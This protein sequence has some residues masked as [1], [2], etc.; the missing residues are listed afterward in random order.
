MESSAAMS[1]ATGRADDSPG[2]GGGRRLR[3]RRPHLRGRTNVGQVE[4]TLSLVAGGALAVLGLRRRGLAGTALA[5]AG[6]ALVHRGASGHCVVYDSLGV[7]TADGGR[8]HLE[9]QHGPAAVLD[10]SHAARIEHTVTVARPR[11]EL[12]RYWRRLEN[13]PR[14]MRHLESVTVLDDRR[15]R[16]TAKAPAGTTVE[17]VAVIHNEIEDE[18]LAWKS[19]PG[20]SIANAGSVHFTDAPDG[21]TTLRVL[22]EY[23]PPAGQLGRAVARLL[24]EEP[25]A[26]VRDDL[27]RFRAAMERGEGL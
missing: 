1:D 16:W 24:G 15:S 14:V 25:D 26:Q 5:A 7:S 2:D 11:A 23:D 12:Y 9:Q 18:L 6:A 13:L 17:W 20:A 22:L 4:R 10:A 21:G 19:E 8:P 27:Q 3:P